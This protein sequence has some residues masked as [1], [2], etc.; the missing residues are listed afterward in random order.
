MICDASSLSSRKLRS[1]WANWSKSWPNGNLVL[2]F[3]VR[4]FL[5]VRVLFWSLLVVAP[6]FHSAAAA[7]AAGNDIRL[8]GLGRPGVGSGA[9]QTILDDP[10]VQRYRAM[11]GELS[12][13]LTPKATQPAETLG[14]SGFEFAITNTLTN[15]DQDQPYWTGQPGSPIFEGVAEGRNMPG[16]LWTPTFSVRKGLPFSIDVGVHGTFLTSSR[17]V[18]VGSDI[19]VA[20]HESY[21]PELPAVALRAS[22]NQLLGSTDLSIF[23]TQTDLLFSQAYGVGGVVQITPYLGVGQLFAHVNSQIIDETPYSTSDANDQTGG[24]SGSLYTFPTLEWRD[25][26]FLKLF[27]GARLVASTFHASYTFDL[28][29]LPYDFV[30]SSTVISHSFKIG[31]DV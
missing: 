13:A 15:I 25:N 21:V 9:S 22:V 1:C 24:S 2:L 10:A 17:M 20:L 11:T 12:L 5:P 4:E 6:L 30:E 27:G 14:M 28:G 19:K 16:V 7:R 26:R 31:F 3:Q 23:T 29:F 18:M 8:R